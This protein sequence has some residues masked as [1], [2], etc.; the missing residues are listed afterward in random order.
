MPVV[1]VSIG[2]SGSGSVS[3]SCLQE[4][5]ENRIIPENKGIKYFET[6]FNI[7]R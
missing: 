5:A 7:G 4:M 3:G 6:G 2:I 1:M